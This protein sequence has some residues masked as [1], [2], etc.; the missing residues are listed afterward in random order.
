MPPDQFVNH[1]TDYSEK[2]DIWSL[3]ATY[4][5]LLVGTPPFIDV[6]KTRL[7]NKMREGYYEIPEWC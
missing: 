1:N 2:F 5:E 3:G 4:Y 6:T 7:L